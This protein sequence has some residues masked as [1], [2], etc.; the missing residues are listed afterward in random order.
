V[1]ALQHLPRDRPGVTDPITC[2]ECE[3]RKGQ[4][5]GPLFL[6]CQFCGG[7]GSV[8]GENEP[9]ERGEKPPPPPPTATGH[10]VWADPLVSAAF[11]CRLCFGSRKVAHI[12][13]E[14]GTLVQVPCVCVSDGAA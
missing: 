4:Q 10:R 13:D 1:G 5:Y 7:S 9:A 6:A 12:D 3:G 11:P 14:A 2:P 8:G